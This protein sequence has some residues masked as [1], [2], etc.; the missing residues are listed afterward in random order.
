MFPFWK[1]QTWPNDDGGVGMHRLV[2]EHPPVAV[3][4]P[5]PRAVV[6][7]VTGGSIVDGCGTQLPVNDTGGGMTV[8][9][10]GLPVQ[11]VTTHWPGLSERFP[12][13]RVWHPGS[14]K[15]SMPALPHSAPVAAGQLQPH[16]AA[17]AVRPAVPS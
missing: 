16:T 3:A 4:P 11:S 13:H 7:Q 14:W 5:H 12:S 17:G 1:T 8:T 9:D 15:N 2:P 6:A 10:S